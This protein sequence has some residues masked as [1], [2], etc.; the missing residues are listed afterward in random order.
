MRFHL[1]KDFTSIEKKFKTTALFLD[2]ERPRDGARREE[3][4]GSLPGKDMEARWA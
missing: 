2:Q 1:K 4:R 3:V